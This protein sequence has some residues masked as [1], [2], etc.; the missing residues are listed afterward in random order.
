MSPALRFVELVGNYFVGKAGRHRTLDPGRRCPAGVEGILQDS[1]RESFKSL[2]RLR[3]LGHNEEGCRAWAVAAGIEPC[4]GADNTYS[5]AD[6]ADF[7]L[8]DGQGH[9]GLSPDV[10]GKA[11]AS[12]DFY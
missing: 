3:G 1:L 7:E 12:G 5:V 9:E 2:I 10:A 8:V 11:I 6:V 4:V